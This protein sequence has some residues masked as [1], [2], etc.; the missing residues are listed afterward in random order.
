M[1]EFFS[2]FFEVFPKRLIVYGD[3]HGCLD[4]FKELRHK[5]TPRPNDIEV[6]LGDIINKGPHSKELIEYFMLH[7]ILLITGN[8]EDKILRYRRFE[9]LKSKR[10]PIILSELQK[11]VYHSLSRVHFEYLSKAPLFYRFGKVTLLHAGITNAMRL[12][13]LGKKESA[14]I[15]HIRWLD[16]KFHFVSIEE[17][18]N[19]GKYFWSDVYDG[20][21]GFVVYGHQP[22]K[23]VKVNKN[24]LGIDTGCAYGNK[25]TAAVFDMD[26]DIVE[27]LNYSIYQVNAKAVYS[28]KDH[29][30]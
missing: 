6:S 7:K 21:S 14:L 10:N 13:T 3:V 17:T 4:E 15:F 28:V 25:L 16:K 29:W 26:Y 23:E 24:A 19:K 30:I 12:E 22:F 27:N 8:H 11:K 2:K 18:K 1:F 20:G 9:K 5:I